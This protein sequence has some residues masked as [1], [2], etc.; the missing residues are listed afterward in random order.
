[1]DASISLI[2][3]ILVGLV[4]WIATM[5]MGYTFCVGPLPQPLT[6]ALPIGL[7]MG[8]VPQAMVVGAYIQMVYIG[9]IA[10]LG[11][12]TNV[13][14]PLAASVVIPIALATGMEPEVAV[15]IA[16]PFGV[17][18][19]NISHVQRIILTYFAHKADKYAEEANMAGIERCALVYPT[20]VKLFL[21]TIPVALI[22]YLGPSVVQAGLEALPENILRGFS[23]AGGLLPAMGFGLTLKVINRKDLLHYFFAGFFLIKFSGLS[24]TAAAIFGI[25]LAFMYLRSKEAA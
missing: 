7:I 13:D 14:K 1:M 16:I 4:Y 9:I 3:A 8:N 17:L 15:A 24:I 6:L 21:R 12:V 19:A 18:G 25:I 5:G 23:V 2:Q 11:G 20:I 22:V 10:G